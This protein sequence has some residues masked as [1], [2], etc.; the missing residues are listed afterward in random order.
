VDRGVLELS[1][2]LYCNPWFLVKKKENKYR[3]INVAM[4]MNSVTIRDAYLLP[5]VDEFLEEFAGYA[6]AS[7]IDFFSG[8]D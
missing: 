3:L 5:L 7:L 8:Y 4:K 6:I 1:Y 2:S